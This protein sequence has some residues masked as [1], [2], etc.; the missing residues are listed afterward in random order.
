MLAILRQSYNHNQ[1]YH[2]LMQN[3][4][5]FVFIKCA[6]LSAAAVPN[7][8]LSHGVNGNIALTVDINELGRQRPAAC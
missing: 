7:Q 3:Q 2:I 5:N 8:M 1:S 6:I 4:P